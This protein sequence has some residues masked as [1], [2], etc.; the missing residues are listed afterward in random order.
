[1]IGDSG[2]VTATDTDSNRFGTQKITIYRIET[3]TP[4][5]GGNDTITTGIGRDYIFGGAGSDTITTGNGNDVALGDNG[6]ADFMVNDGN[7]QTIDVIRSTDPLIG[8]GDV[9]QA[10]GGDDIV[11]G[12][13]G[14]DEIRGDSGYDILLGDHGLVDYSRPSNQIFVSIFTGANEGGGDDTI[15]GGSEDD[16][17]LGQQGND[18]IYGGA[19]QDDIT[20]GHNVIGGSDG[21]DILYGGDKPGSPAANVSL[22]NYV[23]PGDGSD[24][25]LGDNGIITRTVVGVDAWRTYPAPF[26]DVI[27][28]VAPFDNIDFVQGND[29]IYGDAGQDSIYGQRGDD[30]LNGG[31][32]DDEIM[33]GLGS[34]SIT[35]GDGNDMLLGD[36]GQIVRA[37]DTDGSPVLNANGSWHRDVI[38]EEIGSILGSV[39]LD[40]TP[41][42]VTDPELAHKLLLTD[43]LILGGSLLPGGG[44]AVNPDT[45]AW[46]TDLLLIDLVDSSNDSISGG[47]GDDII[48]G[49]RGD[50][51]LLG[52]GGNDILF[53]DGVTNVVPFSTNIPQVM[54]VLR[55]ITIAPDAGVNVIL[56][57]GGSL[58]VPNITLRADEYDFVT[59]SMTYV[60]NQNPAFDAIASKDTLSRTDGSV[61]V[62]YI[63]LI[64]DVVHHASF[65]SGND[66][67]DGGSGSD[68]I[69]GDDMTIYAPLFTGLTQIE[70]AST[71]VTSEMNALLYAMHHLGQDFDLYENTV[72]GVSTAHDIRFGNDVINGG[73]GD[74]IISG[75]NTIYQ[76]PF[77]IGLPTEDAN[78]TNAALRY[79][80]FLRDIEHVGMDFVNVAGVAHGQ[81]LNGLVAAAIAENPGKVRPH[82]QDIADPNLHDLWTHNDVISAGAGNDVVVGDDLRILFPVLNGNTNDF[83]HHYTNVSATTWYATQIALQNQEATRDAELE[84]HLHANHEN[85]ENYLPKDSD[86]ALIPYD[87]EY[88]LNSGND[89]ISGGGGDDLIV[90]DFAL[91]VTPIV[92]QPGTTSNGWYYQGSDWL[93]KHLNG[94]SHGWFDQS[95]F[96]NIFKV[97]N[98]WLGSA[99]SDWYSHDNEWFDFDVAQFLG[100]SHNRHYWS[101]VGKEFFDGHFDARHVERQLR[102]SNFRNVFVSVGNDSITGEDGNDAMIADNLI[103]VVPYGPAS[104]A[105]SGGTIAPYFPTK[106]ALGYGFFLKD[107]RHTGS[108]D[109]AFSDTVS[110]GSG[111]DIIAGQQGADAL[112]GGLGNDQLFGGSGRDTLTGGG[113]SDT[114]K[115][116]GNGN[117][118]T[119]IN[120]LQGLFLSSMSPVLERFILDVAATGGLIRPTGDVLRLAI[121]GTTGTVFGQTPVTS[122]NVSI[123]GSVAGVRGQL[124]TFNG[125]SAS[126]LTGNATLQWKVLDSNNLILGVGAGTTLQFRP[127]TVGTY[128]IVFGIGTDTGAVGVTTLTL[129]V[130]ATMLVAD[131]SSPGKFILIVGGTPNNDNIDILKGSGTGT[132]RVTVD[133]GDHSTSN[134]DQTFSNISQVQ[135][136]GGL[137]DDDITINTNLGVFN[138]LLDG[139][140]GYDDLNGGNG[141]DQLIGGFGEDELSGGS[142]N[143]TLDGGPNDDTLRGG[144]GN[145]ILTGGSGNDSIH[146]DKGNDSLDGGDGS[147][148][149]NGDDGDDMIAGGNGDDQLFGEQGKDQLDGGNG[150]DTLDGGTEDDI[151]AGGTGNDELDGSDGN[152]ALNGG[153]GADYLDGGKGNDILAGGDGNDTLLGNDG[154][155][156]LYGGEGND[157]I[158]G[159]SGNDTLFGDNGDDRL[160]GGNDV[161]V[162]HGGDGNDSLIGG[163]GNDT[164]YGEAGD[165]YLSAGGGTD[166]M[167]GGTGTNYTTGQVL[168]RNGELFILGTEGADRITIEIKSGLLKVTAVF[169][170]ETVT[171]NFTP[172]AITRIT[173]LLLDGN[174]SLTITTAVTQDVLIDAG[175]GDDNVTAGGGKA[176]IYGG[177]G[178]DDL[179][180]GVKDD[181]IDGGDGDDLIHGAEGNDRLV[182]GAGDDKIYGDDGNDTLEG[183]AGADYLDGGAGDDILSG[184][185]WADTL[186]GGDGNDQLFGDGGNDSLDGGRGDDILHGGNQDDSLAGGDGNDILLGENGEDTLSGGKGRDLLIGGAGSDD[187]DGSEDDDILIGGNTTVPN[188]AGLSA[189][190]AAW[191]NATASYATR[192]TTLHNMGLT[193]GSTVQN[194]SFT[195]YLK[196]G[197]GTDWF[198]V[199]HNG[200][201]GDDDRQT[202]LSSGETTDFIS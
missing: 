199:D 201:L 122:L 31:A 77:M 38:L 23:T 105:P 189:L 14:N 12:G 136:Y 194:D 55:L 131:P 157:V 175:S 118:R 121:D 86:L 24:I 154:N 192:I 142:G 97:K 133:D 39:P 68:V 147:D 140:P 44:K 13:F 143:D 161:D 47:E 36:A 177:A 60:P 103:L 46:D 32:G 193:S 113:G 184:G 75:D 82:A 30:T 57:A 127:Q 150:D 128:R 64:P 79:Y 80:N 17:I 149:L 35:G 107:P 120:I 16:F 1:V 62:P 183:G 169:S 74:D 27:R 76:V 187:L 89:I 5:D 87:F 198:F 52:G 94:G 59:P 155:D 176:T 34:D 137:G 96:D 109:V 151:L 6:Y 90:G 141:N 42:R 50:D 185:D 43:L 101:D 160:E 49:Q 4:A 182:G 3:V 124:L 112:D 180:G 33:A 146:G 167:D 114:Q 99:G 61:F 53:G 8:G 54:N 190:R 162:L 21:S 51:S 153:A 202:D 174:D 10:G 186:N 117:T 181:F 152:D 83:A 156:I 65:M 129:Q 91:F 191:S 111:N 104:S 108:L 11:F 163:S 28:I 100:R 119:T 15:Y 29:S 165:D 139:G 78:F 98:N 159:D 188:D 123:S 197:S 84:T 125:Q 173:V 148:Y 106:Y 138:G 132:V 110:G 134:L 69:V 66:Y 164:L 58:I 179:E 196:G 71:D 95:W 67:L 92:L 18:T 144:D 115:W 170:T 37:F 45:G 7:P 22:E 19:G 88:D 116:S 166:T 70:R 102:Y 158:H 85:M 25:I 40:T 145:D 171:V 63:S 135:V 178:D 72:E 130:T 81:V 48:F 168:N 26:A 195:D 9:I 126:S 20:G 172:A 73:D 93:D 200:K 41:L 56:Q 2:L